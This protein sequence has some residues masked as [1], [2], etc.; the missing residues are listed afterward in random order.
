MR[1]VPQVEAP[2]VAA[3]GGLGRRFGGWC[4]DGKCFGRACG[5]D[6]FGCVAIEPRRERHA[7]GQSRGAMKM[8]LCGENL[9]ET[10]LPVGRQAAEIL[11]TG[12]QAQRLAEVPRSFSGQA[13]VERR[14]LCEAHATG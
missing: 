7:S 10:S 1:L 12:R 14:V 6:R 4:G 2:P 5:C 13:G 11:A 8:F 9:T 3:A